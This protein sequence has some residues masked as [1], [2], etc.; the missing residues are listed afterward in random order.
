MG[1]LMD[2]LN[3]I[4]ITLLTR[5]LAEPDPKQQVSMN[6]THFIYTFTAFI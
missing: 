3:Y 6:F 4:V 1:E 2:F 5:L